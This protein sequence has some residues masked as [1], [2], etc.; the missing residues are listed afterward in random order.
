LRCS[1]NIANGDLKQH[2]YAIHEENIESYI[3]LLQKRIEEL[4]SNML[5]EKRNSKLNVIH[6]ER[7]IKQPGSKLI[8]MDGEQMEG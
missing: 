2:L 4:E 6:D 3:E 1:N 5:K 8:D 7:I